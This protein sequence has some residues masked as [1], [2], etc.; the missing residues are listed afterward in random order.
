VDCHPGARNVFNVVRYEIGPRDC[1]DYLDPGTS[2][3]VKRMNGGTCPDGIA[4]KPKKIFK[5]CDM[6]LDMEKALIA[7]TPKCVMK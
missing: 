7:P 3:E 1:W 4:Y 6:I 5:M 2:N